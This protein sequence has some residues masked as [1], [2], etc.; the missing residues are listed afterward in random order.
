M[1]ASNGTAVLNPLGVAPQALDNVYIRARSRPR[2]H[3][4]RGASIQYKWTVLTVT[5]VGVLM[6]GIDSRIMIVGLPRIA[7]SLRADA[8][9]AIW[10]TQAYVLGSTCALLLIGRVS[11]VVGR[12]KIYTSGFGV[13]TFGS[14]LVSLAANAPMA[15]AFRFIQGLGSA[16]LFTNSAAMIVDAVPEKELGFFLGINQVAFR[17][18]AMAGLTVSGVLL[19]FFDWRALFYINLPI[20]IFGTLW[21]QRRLRE[22]AVIEAGAP[23]DWR[24]FATFV[25]FISSLLLALTTAAYGF[26]SWETFTI[27]GAVSAIA[28]MLFVAFELRTPSPLLDLRLLRIREYSGGLVAQLLNAIAF[29][30]VLLLLSLYF[31]LVRGLSPLQTGLIIIP[32]DIASVALGP[33]SGKLSDR[34]GHLPFTTGGLAVVSLSLFL[35]AT[36]DAFTPMPLVIAYMVVFGAGLGIFASPNM[37]SIMGSVPPERRGIASGFRATFF[38]VGFVLSLNLAILAMAFTVP[39]AFVSK[40]IASGDAVAFTTAQRALFQSGLRTA[41]LW[42]ALLNSAAIVPSLLR[43][44]RVRNRRPTTAAA[45]PEA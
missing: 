38:N 8:E 44:R 27:L 17:A 33:L 10:L 39:Y 20:G 41:F 11:D 42:M 37:S 13:F 23:I 19:S 12:V 29:G 15:I 6:A 7:E 18:G 1:A 26:A 30:A 3:P 4:P 16:I 21:A 45:V 34:F 40:V 35:F 43:G 5:T 31:Q 25:V 2:R 28:L 32:L 22:I 36:T 14:L 9:Q 24:G